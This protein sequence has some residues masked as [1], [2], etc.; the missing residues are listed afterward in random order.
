MLYRSLSLAHCHGFLNHFVQEFQ[1]SAN[2]HTLF[3]GFDEDFS[4]MYSMHLW[5]HLWWDEW[6]TDFTIVHGGMIDEDY[7]RY[8]ETT[9][10]IAAR[11]FLV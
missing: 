7:V 5:A 2:V 9:Y 4:G 6:R 1:V 10:A 3:E 11:K 8:A